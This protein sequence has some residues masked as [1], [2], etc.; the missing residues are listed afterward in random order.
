[1]TGLILSSSTKIDFE[2]SQ[3]LNYLYVKAFAFNQTLHFVSAKPS[4]PHAEASWPV[5]DFWYYSL[6]LQTKQIKH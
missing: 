3:S 1:M 5:L 6:C 4:V 2:D